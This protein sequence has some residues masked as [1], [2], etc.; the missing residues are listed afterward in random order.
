MHCPFNL[1]LTYEM[2][3]V[4]HLPHYKHTHARAHACIK[5][6]YSDKPQKKPTALGGVVFLALT[7][8]G[9][10]TYFA[11]GAILLHTRGQ[12]GREL[13]IHQTFWVSTSIKFRFLFIFL[14]E[15]PMVYTR[16]SKLGS[17]EDRD[18]EKQRGMG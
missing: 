11:I 9:M 18:G 3:M 17:E 16:R 4:C 8:G 1:Y 10:A 7:L 15:I 14:K 2:L 13:I 5:R 12:T 6:H